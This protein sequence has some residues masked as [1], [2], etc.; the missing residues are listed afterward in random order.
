MVTQAYHLNFSGHVLKAN[1]EIP[2]S[3]KRA[4]RMSLEILEISSRVKEI[5]FFF[6]DLFGFGAYLNIYVEPIK[7]IC[8]FSSALY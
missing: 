7:S 3:L 5:P 1:G 2:K 6:V 4:M 8:C